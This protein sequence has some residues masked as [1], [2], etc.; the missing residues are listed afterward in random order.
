[1]LFASDTINPGKFNALDALKKIVYFGGDR[2]PYFY[3]ADTRNTMLGDKHTNN[4]S[5]ISFTNSFNA[6]GQV[7]DE[8]NDVDAVI[9]NGSTYAFIA[10]ASTTAQLAVINVTDI[11]N[12]VL[13]AKRTLSGVTAVDSTAWGWRTYYYAGLL[14]VTAGPE[15]HIFD[16]SNPA[17]PS[18]VGSKELNTTVNDF[19][20]RDG[21]AYFA[22]DSDARGPLLVY[23]VSDP[24]HIS[25]VVG[26][27]G[28]ISGPQNGLSIFLIGNR[29]YLGGQKKSP[30]NELYILDASS[31]KTAVGGLP[32]LGPADSD[33][34]IGSDINGIRVAGSFA[35][36]A[37]YGA[38]SGGLKVF[39]ISN[40]VDIKPV[41]LTF[42]FGNKPATIDYGDSFLY[43]AS[44]STPNFQILYSP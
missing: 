15:L 2:V 21:L 36:V 42:N 30:G 40:S 6:S 16:V 31:P 17:S 32:I 1:V 7:I 27:R 14:Y 44:E 34:D 41:N 10:M 35:F 18:E 38:A 11:H 25:E 3:I 26:A 29:L 4:P 37:Q 20:V 24:A 13:V 33:K 9:L 22:V 19:V 39:D 8:I 12:P 5:I 23:D 43:A 28:N